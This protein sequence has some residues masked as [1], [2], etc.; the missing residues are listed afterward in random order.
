LK[1]P[2]HLGADVAVTETFRLEFGATDRCPSKITFETTVEAP[3]P[4]GSETFV[5]LNALG[6]VIAAD[7]IADGDV[8]AFAIA[9]VNTVDA[10]AGTLA[11]VMLTV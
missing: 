4:A 9:T 8:D 10:P 6:N 1:L 7:W 11:G 3:L 5:T 2:L